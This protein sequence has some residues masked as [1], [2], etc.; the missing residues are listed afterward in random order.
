MIHIKF[1]DF[2]GAATNN[3]AS[4]QTGSFVIDLFDAAGLPFFDKSANIPEATKFYYGGR[5]LNKGIVFPLKKKNP[6][7]DLTV[8]FN[9]CL[10]EKSFLAFA[11]K[12]NLKRGR[13]AHVPFSYALAKL[14]YSILST[15]DNDTTTINDFDEWYRKAIA[16]PYCYMNDTRNED[17]INFL[18]SEI[19]GICPITKKKINPKDYRTFKIVHIYKKDLDDSYKKELKDKHNIDEPEFEDDYEN[20]LMVSN[21]YDENSINLIE[22]DTVSKVVELFNAKKPI[23][24][25]AKIIS[26]LN[27]EELS[28]KLK[29]CISRIA[30][31]TLP[32]V[33]SDTT[34]FYDP[35]AIETKMGPDFYK[36]MYSTIASAYY[37]KIKSYFNSNID[38]S[39]KEKENLLKNVRNAYESISKT[40]SDKLLII[41]HL[42]NWF[43]RELFDPSERHQFS[44]EALIMVCYFIQDCEVFGHDIS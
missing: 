16:I 42:Q 39:Q 20:C 44:M 40:T 34:I 10:G 23:L 41:E 32:K 38:I 11:D 27:D 17:Y 13:Y 36:E 22:D 19:E 2:L 21:S 25:R 7:N 3:N 4:E 29:L 28:E 30:S 8:F 9:G 14:C 1:I 26:Q 43:L 5:N 6:I 33:E 24:L 31:S 12:L 18:C 15:C 35:I 37:I